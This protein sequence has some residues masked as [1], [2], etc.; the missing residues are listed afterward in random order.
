[1]A[2]ILAGKGVKKGSIVGLMLE[3][4]LEAVVAMLAIMKA[5]GAY[6]PIDPRMP[7]KRILT[8]LRDSNAGILL[9]G[10]SI[11]QKL[12]FTVLQGLENKN[13]RPFY[14]PPRKQVKDRDFPVKKPAPDAL[15]VLFLDL[16]RY[17]GS[18]GIR[19]DV[20]GPPLEGMV[21]IACPEGRWGEKVDIKTLN[22]LK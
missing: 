16:S 20:A 15:K 3:R 1:M 4:S 13:V 18:P 19:H 17:F 21:E 11:V 2:W 22:L 5:G 7:E 6:L 8:M 9:T 10:S 12:P 14:T